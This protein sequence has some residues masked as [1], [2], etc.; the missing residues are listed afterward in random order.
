MGL[1]E[2]PLADASSRQD[3]RGWNLRV[4][5]AKLEASWA[6][7]NKIERSLGLEGGNSSST[8]AWNDV[9]TVQEGNSHVLAI[10]RV[11]DNHLVIRLKALDRSVKAVLAGTDAF[12]SHWK[13]RSCTLKLSCPL[14]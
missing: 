14:L 11:A 10:A 3:I 6:P 4:V 2:R 13:V 1:L 9:S 12:H 7:F 5:D 8:V